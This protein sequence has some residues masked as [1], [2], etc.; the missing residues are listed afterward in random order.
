M[1]GRFILD[2]PGR[3]VTIGDVRVWAAGVVIYR[4]DSR[5][6][7]TVVGAERNRAAE[8]S[9]DRWRG[10]IA[11]EAVALGLI[12]PTVGAAA[13]PAVLAEMVLDV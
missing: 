7:L 3:F 6:L 11:A 5:V 9:I 4:S 10:L 13:E 8:M 2:I 1:S 12:K